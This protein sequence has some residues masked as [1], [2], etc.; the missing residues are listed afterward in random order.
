LQSAL[1]EADCVIHC[2]LDSKAKGRDFLPT[3]RALNTEILTGALAGRCRLYVFVSSQVVYAG[4]DPADPEG[5]R[6]DQPL[7]LSSRED[8]YTR[9]K[10]ESEREVIAA[11]TA[12]GVPYLIVRPTVVMGPGM[13]WSEGVVA[14]SRWLTVGVRGRT[15]NLV[16]VDDLSQQLLLLIDGGAGN[17]VFNLG[18]INVPTDAYFAQVGAIT[19]RRPRFLPQ[20]LLR[21]AAR[22]IP[23]TLWFFAR[24]VAIDCSKV[25]AA[26]G[27]NATRDLSD[28]FGRRPGHAA[29]NSLDALRERLASPEPFRT[30]GQGYHLWFNPPHAEDRL[31]MTGYSGIISLEADRIRVKA[32]TRLSEICR[33]LDARGLQLATLP[34][35]LGISAGACFFVDVHGSSREHFSLF[36]LIEEIRYL[37]EQGEEIVSLRDEALWA[38]LR[39]RESRFILTELTFRCEP[40]TWLSNRMEWESEGDL[41]SYLAGRFREDLATTIQWYPHYRRLLVYHVNRVAGRQRGAAR[42]VAP[43]RG[44]PFPFQRVFLAARLRGRKLQIDKAFR[45]LAPWQYLPLE[46]FVAWLYDRRRATWR[47]MEMCLTLEDG[48]V[49]V[50]ELRRLLDRGDMSMRKRASV[51]IRF[52]HDQRS[53]RDYTWVEFV[54]DVPELVERVVVMARSLATEGVRFHRGKYV[55]R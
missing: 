26:T 12:A 19:G 41:D 7:V 55:P 35:F 3:N 4:T 53:G 11:C 45:I 24:N 10:I 31:A 48:R 52:S 1:A 22:A 17:D 25:A 13:A 28:Y 9:L 51:G 47:D 36:E 37:D 32:G 40:A 39:S 21:L 16:Y 30:H 23:S 42:S 15:M 44:I 2:A 33:A 29:P 14:A 49:L 54:S 27:F 8:D 18:S 38:E 5:Y 50:A 43:F 6:E 20:R 34:E 46:S